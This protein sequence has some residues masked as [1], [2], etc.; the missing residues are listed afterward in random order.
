MIERLFDANVHRH[1]VHDVD[2]PLFE[3]GRVRELQQ[4]LA[5]PRRVFPQQL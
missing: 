5:K 4:I 1:R 3:Q 2:E